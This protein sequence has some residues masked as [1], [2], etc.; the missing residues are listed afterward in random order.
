MWTPAKLKDGT[1]TNWGLGFYIRNGSEGGRI[2]ESIGNIAGFR[3][4][5]LYFP[6]DNTSVIVMQNTDTNPYSL[7]DTVHRLV[8]AD[9]SL[10]P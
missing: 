5:I 6:D 7:A 3:T 8:A 9:T 4:Q 1:A 10:V 2:V